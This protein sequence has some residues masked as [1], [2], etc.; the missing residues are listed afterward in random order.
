MPPFQRQPRRQ[1]LSVVNL[2]KLAVAGFIFTFGYHVYPLNFWLVVPGAILFGG[3]AILGSWKLL[4]GKRWFA[5]PVV[6]AILLIGIYLVLDTAGGRLA[7]GVAPR[8]AAFF[9]PVLLLVVGV[10]AASL[11]GRW[12]LLATGVLVLINLASLWQR[13]N[14][15]WS[16]GDLL[17]FRAA[18]DFASQNLPERGSDRV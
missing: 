2:A 12:P 10:G 6:Y 13:W 18:A 8:H 7:G 9:A 11:P 17:D 15:S 16:Y 5:I 1:P 4:T 14:G 3:L